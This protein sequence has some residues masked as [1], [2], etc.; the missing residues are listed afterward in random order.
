MSKILFAIA[1][2]C[3]V[4]NFSKDIKLNIEKVD[5]EN[6]KNSESICFKQTKLKNKNN[7]N[8]EEEESIDPYEPI[9]GSSGSGLDNGKYLELELQ[10]DGSYDLPEDADY[11][12]EE[13]EQLLRYVRPGDIMYDSVGLG[14][15]GSGSGH[16]AIIEGIAHSS[17]YNKDY[18]VTIEANPFRGVKRGYLDKERFMDCKSILRVK[19]ATPAIINDAIYFCQQQLDKKYDLNFMRK[20]TSI[21]SNE[22][23]CSEL[24]W[25]AYK[26]NENGIDLANGAL[27]AVRPQDINADSDTCNI[28]K[29]NKDTTF[30]WDSNTHTYHCDGDTFTESH[31][32]DGIHQSYDKCTICEHIFWPGC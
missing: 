26:Y 14:A 24:V 15:D 19:N 1:I 32:H 31:N 5:L 8:E 28:M 4:G 7:V 12:G 23:Y 17:K 13:G 29:H 30:T 25:A 11:S 22:W 3:L 16:V 21:D 27:L 10:S 9:D 2:S 6:A 18:I 20:H